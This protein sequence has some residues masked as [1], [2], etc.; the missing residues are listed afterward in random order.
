[1][2]EL[3]ESEPISEPLSEPDRLLNCTGLQFV[4]RRSR[5]LNGSVM[6]PYRTVEVT[7]EGLKV[8]YIT[9]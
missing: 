9:N 3:T 6:V 1:M 2:S 8:S 7:Y 5:P 4:C